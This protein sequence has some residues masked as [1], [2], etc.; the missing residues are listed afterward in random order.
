M[1]INAG[2]IHGSLTLNG[3]QYF[4]TLEKADSKTKS[5]ENKMNQQGK[6]ME[7]WGKDWTLKVTTPIIGTGAAA[8]KLG[9]DFGHSMS[10]VGA[11]SGSTGSELAILEKKARDMGATTK[12][13]ASDAADGLKYMAMAGWDT[14]A[15]L[16][17]LDG[18]LA[19]AAASGEDLG[20][21]SDIVTDALTAFGLEAKQAGHFA[22]VLAKASS[23]SNTNVGL[24]GETFKYVAPLAGA[25]GYSVEDTTLAIGLMANAGIKGS[26]AGTALRSMLTRLIKPTEESGT[27]M[28]QLG[29]SMTNS[30]GTMKSLSEVMVLLRD[31]FKDLDP[32]QQAF[33]AAQIA[34]QEAMSGF[35]AIVNA[36]DGDFNS[37]QRNIN[38][39]TGAAKEMSDMM[40]D[41][42]KGRWQE[43]KS[44]LE[45]TALQIYDLLLPSLEKWLAKG[46]DFLEWFSTLDDGTKKTIINIAGFAAAIGPALLIGGKFAQSIGSIAG[47]FTKYTAASTAA[48][49]ATAAAG[50][51]FTLAGVASK[52]GALLLNPWVLGIAA[53]TA[54]GIAL[55]KHLQKDSI[56]AVEL[57]GDEVSESTQKAVE[58]FLELEEKATQ[59]LDEMNWKGQEVTKEMADNISE[60]FGQMKEQVVAK[61]E[62][63]KNNSLS[64]LEEMF[65]NS[66]Y[67][68]DESKKDLINTT[69]NMY[70]EQ[71]QLAESRNRRINNILQKAA[72]ENR[73]LTE[74]ERKTINSIKEGMKEDGIR[75]LSETE[76]E[77]LAIL[78]RL[79]NESGKISAL[80]AAEV[81]RNSKKQKDEAI[82][83]A[84]EEYNERLKVAAELRAQGTKEAEMLADQVVSEAKKQK[85][86]SIKEAEEMHKKVVDEAKAQAKEHINEVDWTTGEVK[87]KWEVMR[88]NAE[89]RAKEIKKAFIDHAKEQKRQVI[90]L[91]NQIKQGASKAWNNMKEGASEKFH[92]IKN[93]I[94]DNVSTAKEKWNTNVENMR[95]KSVEKFNNMKKNTSEAFNKI[96]EKIGEGI[97]KIKDWNKQ[98]AENKEATFTTTIKQVFQTIG[99]K[100]TGAGKNAHGTNYWRGGLTWVG[101]Q[102]PELIELPK[103]SKVF[104]NEKSEKI[105]GQNKGITQNIHIHSPEP[106]SPSEIA[107]KNL[108]VSRQ[109]AME[110]GV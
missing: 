89:N 79:K 103:G 101:E 28:K 82:K 44:L 54:G 30:D 80:Q 16:E 47:L 81:V 90:E 57:F 95:S 91:N 72:N 7:K 104:S 24:M 41:N 52:A 94:V 92:S 34:G 76:K 50:K 85:K 32:E 38:N 33:Y 98:K 21:V 37:L 15:M 26:Q 2:S 36:S 74:A 106:L 77:S 39:S 4:K 59:S 40:Q 99:E 9:I 97:N 64:V 31:K 8:T 58:G 65:A 10:E 100:I 42:L 73:E 18:V 14:N 75:S 108:Q 25:M 61:L 1:S 67:M 93:S 110:W 17:G 105:A 88:D 68:T 84:E 83:N 109:L 107:R 46:K 96:K 5:F 63:K 102:G 3:E 69:T 13:S 45:E 56:P 12:F 71:I 55:A 20:M 6:K 86:N 60:N 27:A 62:E 51:G 78:E 49:T 53:A 19:L 87:S 11:I 48:T 29:I 66:K 43:F 35:L 23:S 22:D 70:D